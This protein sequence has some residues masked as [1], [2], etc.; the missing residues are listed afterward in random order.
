MS[1]QTEKNL[2]ELLNSIDKVTKSLSEMFDRGS[3][4]LNDVVNVGMNSD[5]QQ[6]TDEE[7]NV[8]KPFHEYIAM[9]Y[10][11]REAENSRIQSFSRDR[12][13]GY[14]V[15]LP[16]YKLNPKQKL[17]MYTLVRNQKAIVDKD[18]QAIQAILDL[19]GTKE[20]LGEMEKNKNELALAM[21]DLLIG[22]EKAQKGDEFKQNLN[23]IKAKSIPKIGEISQALI[24]Q[25]NSEKMTELQQKINE[26]LD[27]IAKSQ[28][29]FP[30][31]ILLSYM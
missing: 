11:M 26:N 20:F 29:S 10:T 2:L 24:K 28:K 3:V 4:S 1:D 5:I 7:L 22:F 9:V 21:H 16:D 12:Y 14:I 17:K 23:E 18:V 25:L 6:F 15:G 30:F 31:E 8:L 19:E 13:L 27:D